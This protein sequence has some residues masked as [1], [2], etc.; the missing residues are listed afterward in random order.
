MNR[1]RL[2]QVNSVDNI[3]GEGAIAEVWREQHESILNCVDQSKYKN[4]V[5]TALCNTKFD[6][7]MH[8]SVAEVADAI[9]NLKTGKSSGSDGLTGEA[10]IYSSRILHI[11]LSLGFTSMLKHGYL[12]KYIIDSVMIPLVKIK[13]GILS[14]KENYRPIALAFFVLQN[15]SLV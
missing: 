12:P 10:F 11:L 15:T 9:K 1:N 8:V 6:S 13:H 14:D 7:G 4:K 5:T 3:C 2:P